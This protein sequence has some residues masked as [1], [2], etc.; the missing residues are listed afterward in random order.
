MFSGNDLF[1]SLFVDIPEN[2]RNPLKITPLPGKYG[3]EWPWWSQ[4][5]GSLGSLFSEICAYLFS[6]SGNQTG[7]GLIGDAHWDVV[8]ATPGVSVDVVKLQNLVNRDSGNT[9][10]GIIIPIDKPLDFAWLNYISYKGSLSYMPFGYYWGAT[11]IWFGIEE[12][13]Q[14]ATT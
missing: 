8:K 2:V 7:Y 14:E 3:E 1:G 5:T 6:S 12:N 4:M 13:T 10:Q 11:R 9:Y